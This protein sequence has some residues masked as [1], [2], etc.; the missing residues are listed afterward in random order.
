MIVSRFS[1]RIGSIVCA[2]CL[3]AVLSSCSSS[4]GSDPVTTTSGFTFRV[5]D[6]TQYQNSTGASFTVTGTTS[7]TVRQLNFTV[8]ASTAPNPIFA[9][10]TDAVFLTD[11]NRTLTGAISSIDTLIMRR[12]G[13]DLFIYNFARQVAGLLPPIALAGSSVVPRPIPTWTKIAELNP[14]AGSTF[15]ADTLRFNINVPFSGTLLPAQLWI[16]ITGQN[17]GSATA[18]VGGGSYTVFRQA[19]TARLLI[20]LGT[21]TTPIQAT[22]TIPIEVLVGGVTGATN[23]P[24]TIHRIAFSPASATF[25]LTVFGAGTLPFNLPG[26]RQELTSFRQGQ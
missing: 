24:A 7:R 20:S 3:V 9:S 19:H 14:T 23:S 22:G 15:T 8:P 4:S 5:G 26:Y 13:T 1:A 11:T 25:D 12:V 18:M 16:V 2:L 21:G 10:F 6:N 17:Q